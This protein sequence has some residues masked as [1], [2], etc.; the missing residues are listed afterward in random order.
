MINPRRTPQVEMHMNFSRMWLALAAAAWFVL[1]G[2]AAPVPIPA[3]ASTS[4]I[5]EA[6]RLRGLLPTTTPLAVI[7]AAMAKEGVLELEYPTLVTLKAIRTVT[8]MRSEEK[9]VTETVQG[10]GGKVEQVKR[11]VTEMVPATVQVEVTVLVPGGK[12]EKMPVPVKSCKFFVVSKEGKLEPLDA[13]KATALLK[14]RTAVLTGASAEVD[15]RTLE[16][17]KPGT[18]CVIY[19]PPPPPPPL[20]YKTEL[21]GPSGAAPPRASFST[22]AAITAST[23]SNVSCNTCRAA[24]GKG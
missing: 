9:T 3:P 13:A 6:V 24:F 8:V 5:A 19:A 23:F 1:P 15:P 14:K 17:I 7:P 4:P 22:A 16:L 21:N 20:P 2:T 12:V 18:L 11:K 10:P